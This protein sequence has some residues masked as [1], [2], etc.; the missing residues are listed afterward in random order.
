MYNVLKVNHHDKLEHF[1]AYA[2]FSLVSI[3]K[4]LFYTS[5]IHQ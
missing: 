3:S 1:L 5:K 4:S 2:H